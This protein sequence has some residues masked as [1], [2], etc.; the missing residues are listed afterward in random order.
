MYQRICVFYVYHDPSLVAQPTVI[1][2]NTAARA[3]IAVL[4]FFI[5]LSS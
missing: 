5:V 2:T 3:V 1:S 4:P